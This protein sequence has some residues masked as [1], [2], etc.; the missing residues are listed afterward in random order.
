MMEFRV[1]FFTLTF[2]YISH[3]LLKRSMSFYLQF[4]KVVVIFMTSQV[5]HCKHTQTHTHAHIHKHSNTLHT[6]THSSLF[7]SKDE[8][9]QSVR[10][11]RIYGYTQTR[12]TAPNVVRCANDDVTIFAATLKTQQKYLL[13]TSPSMITV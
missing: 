2:I 13:Q 9:A 7:A 10:R 5:A 4:T 3:R 12:H 1:T 11:K 8:R 6:Y